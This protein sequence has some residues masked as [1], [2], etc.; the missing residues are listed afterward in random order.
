MTSSNITLMSLLNETTVFD[1]VKL[2]LYKYDAEMFCKMFDV[3][4]FNRKLNE[5]HVKKIYQQLC[6]QKVPHLMGS[7]K[8]I[9]DKD[10]NF[11]VIDG[12]H[13]LEALRLFTTNNKNK[14]VSII[15]EIY[16]VPSVDSDVVLE[17]FTMANNNLNLSIEDDVDIVIK[18]LISRLMKDSKL[19]L[20][21]IDKNN[22]RINRPRISKKVL[23]EELK[24]NMTIE[25]LRL[26][27]DTI[28]DQ[29][30]KINTFIG[31]LT[32]QQLFD[33]NEPSKPQINARCN[34]AKI[35]FFLN[36]G[37]RYTFDKWISMIGT[38][39]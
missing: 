38:M 29:I 39:D 34:A 30:R 25:I 5:E 24:S 11:Q 31:T 37:G 33:T 14:S 7:I 19:R 26:P 1:N 15:V 2:S 35:E 10:N 9:R 8:A 36:M 32:Y 20:G 13:R 18:G 16:D 17:L 21:I 23:Y 27:V 22:G 28:I 12:Q 4:A 6:V 3:W